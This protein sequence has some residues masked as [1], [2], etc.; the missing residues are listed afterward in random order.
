VARVSFP[1][2]RDHV[3]VERWG[4]GRGGDLYFT[5]FN[6]S[7]HAVQ[8]EIQIDFAALRLARSGPGEPSPYA[9]TELVA[10]RDLPLGPSGSVTVPLG[11]DSAALLEI[12]PTTP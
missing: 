11:P 4:P 1:D 2:Q 12:R 6:D 7:P 5:V 3:F 10:G 8:A 9:C